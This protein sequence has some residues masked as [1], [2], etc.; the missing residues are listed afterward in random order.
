MKI[1]QRLTARS[2]SA[3]D[4]RP[5]LIVCLGDSVTHGAFELNTPENP[6]S[7][8]KNRC[9]RNGKSPPNSCWSTCSTATSPA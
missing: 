1:T 3:N 8:A 5:V 4:N 6:R 2:R 9:P 7:P